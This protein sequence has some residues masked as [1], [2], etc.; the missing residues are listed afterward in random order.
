M[1][2]MWIVFQILGVI[3]VVATHTFNRWAGMHS[4]SFLTKWVINAGAQ[5]FIAP[6]FILAYQLAPGFFQPWFLGTTLIAILGFLVSVII[7]GETITILKIIGA[8]L[9]LIGAVLLVI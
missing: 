6:L 1:S 2:V 7:F 9:G 4:I 8:V 5:A 3:G